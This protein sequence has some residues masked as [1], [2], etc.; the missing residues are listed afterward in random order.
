MGYYT[1]YKLSW[2]FSNEKVESNKEL[3]IK[4]CEEA[5]IKIPEFMHDVSELSLNEK[6][7]KTCQEV[8]GKYFQTEWYET[9]WYEH[10]TDVKSVST[11]YPD[12]IFA[13]IGDGEDSG[14]QWIKYFKNGKMQIC[15]AK[16]TFDDFDESKLK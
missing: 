10:E 1:D 13:L 5:G 6:I 12:V 11:E 9:K 16:I 14:D 2:S 3:F 4:E 15:R 7:M 8:V